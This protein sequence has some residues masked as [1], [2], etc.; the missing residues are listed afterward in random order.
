[1]GMGYLSSRGDYNHGSSWGT[2]KTL[3]PDGETAWF[4][5]AVMMQMDGDRVLHQPWR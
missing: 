5:V 3:S 1:M 2:K 4:L